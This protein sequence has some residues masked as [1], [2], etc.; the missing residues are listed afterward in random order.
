MPETFTPLAVAEVFIFGFN[1]Y[2]FIHEDKWRQ[3]V[4]LNT[5]SVTI[6]KHGFLKV[7]LLIALIFALLIY[8]IYLISTVNGQ[9]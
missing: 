2:H 3:L 4:Q 5:T 1:Y 8:S 6:N 7:A 9:I